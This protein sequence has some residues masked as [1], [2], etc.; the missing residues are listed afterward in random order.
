M[1]ELTHQNATPKHFALQLGSL[2][3]LYISVS[4]LIV[5]LFGLIN[6][7]F[8]DATE[9]Y[10][11]IES[12]SNSV[13]LGIAMVLVFFPTY[14]IL[15]RMVNT[16]RRT[17]VS[18][19]YLTLTKWLIYLSLVVGIGALLVDLVVVIM[20][21][22]NGE[23]TERFIYKA[24]AVLVV[25]GAA[26]HYYLLDARGYWLKN[27]SKSILFGIGAGLVAFVAIGYGFSYIE[28]PA[29]VR[30]I[31]LDQT[32]ITDLQTIQYK[33]EEYLMTEQKLPETLNT[34]FGEF[35]APTAPEGR[36]AY[37]YVVTEAGFELCAEFSKDSQADAFPATYIDE[38]AMIQ[39]GNTWQYK[40]G[41]YCFKRVIKK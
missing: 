22:L 29:A 33:I 32:Q 2:I 5:L 38:K 6:L 39:N 30:A 3:S 10:Y 15:T 4:F 26:V 8:P 41:T 36:T 12:A 28:T 35:D 27:E 16:L 31:K 17:E 23:I 25:I 13:R 24:V 21:F 9:G 18:E 34:A 11:M 7:K 20:T 1:N 19:Q 14:L 37:T 40:A